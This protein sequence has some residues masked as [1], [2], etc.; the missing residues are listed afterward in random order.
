MS[1]IRRFKN[2]D[3]PMKARR[4]EKEPGSSNNDEAVL[5]SSLSNTLSMLRSRIG[6]SSD[7]NIR[8]LVN[9]DSGNSQIAIAYIEGLVDQKQLSEL[10]E[11]LIAGN[12]HFSSFTN[13][14]ANHLKG[15]IPIGRINAA[16]MVG[17]LLTAI[18]SGE[19]VVVMDGLSGAIA[20]SISGG[21][22]RSVEEP[23]SQ[24]VVRGPKEGFTEELSTNI[25]LLRQKL[26]TPDLRIENRTIGRFT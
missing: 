6:S 23:S 11:E 22:R 3:K 13:N 26:R 21:I 9:A 19:A 1:F 14:P 7:F 15:I 12:A 8:E 2:N 18:L 16:N 25:A 4:N 24:T 10:M 5:S 17:S 20:I